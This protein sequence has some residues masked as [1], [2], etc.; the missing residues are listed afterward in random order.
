[1]LKLIFLIIFTIC[2][3]TDACNPETNNKLQR[4]L[5]D[6]LSNF[7]AGDWN[8]TADLYADNATMATAGAFYR[9]NEAIRQFYI[10]KFD[11]KDYVMTPNNTEY[12]CSRNIVVTSQDCELKTQDGQLVTSVRF[13]RVL[14][15]INGKWKSIR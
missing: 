7:N 8:A 15:R 2:V 13:M 9:G 11:G 6:Y 10:H 12:D 3:T 4:A 14:R 5:T 1:M